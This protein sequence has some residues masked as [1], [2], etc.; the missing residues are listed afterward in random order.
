MAK[1]FLAKHKDTYI[2]ARVVLTYNNVI[3]DW[4]AGSLNNASSLYP[5]DYLVWY[6]LK[7]GVENNY[8]LFDFGGAG[9][10]DVEYGPREFKRRFGGDLVNHGRHTY[11]HSPQK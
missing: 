4:Y 2:G 6:I 8:K 11:I 7:W 10:P 5:N 9:K 1:F 3:H